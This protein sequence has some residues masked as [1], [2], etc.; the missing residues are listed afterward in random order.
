M[1]SAEPVWTDRRVVA[2]LM[3]R[4]P[5]T[6]P[7]D[8]S[9]ADVRT[10]LDNP[11]VQL[12]LLADGQRF[13]GAVA[14]LPAGADPEAPALDFAEPSPITIRPTES[15]DA[16]FAAASASPYRRAIVLDDRGNLLGLLCL[17]ETLTRF[18]GASVKEAE[19]GSQG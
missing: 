18:C 5:K 16:A 10:V 2:D 4:N 17:N 11:R 13:R 3:L 7:A 6:L 14:E 15:A 9:V 12:V 1:S 19:A 8:A